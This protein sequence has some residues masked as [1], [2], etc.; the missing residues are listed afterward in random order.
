MELYDALDRLGLGR[1][2]YMQ[3]RPERF[4]RPAYALLAEHGAAYSR[5]A[6]F[7]T[8]IQGAP[9][10]ATSSPNHR[11]RSGHSSSLAGFVFTTILVFA[12]IRFKKQ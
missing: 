11:Y 4:R 1:L 9:T 6:I 10:L 7:A 3:T 2:F 8:A 5:N 12:S